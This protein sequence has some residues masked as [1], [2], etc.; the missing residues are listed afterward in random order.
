[1][2]AGCGRNQS[3]GGRPDVPLDSH[4]IEAHRIDSGRARL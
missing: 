4:G 3:P 1:M 2:L